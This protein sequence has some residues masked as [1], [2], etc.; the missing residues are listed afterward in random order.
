[1]KLNTYFFILNGLQASIILTTVA[2]T[3]SMPN[4]AKV[5][6]LSAVSIVCLALFAL[7]ATSRLRRGL[8][9][10]ETSVIEHNTDLST[11][12]GIDEFA[13]SA[14]QLSRQAEH[15]EAISEKNREQTQTLHEIHALISDSNSDSPP[16]SEQ[17]QKQLA[18]LANT[19]AKHLERFT[20]AASKVE[21]ISE[22]LHENTESQG[23]A[24]VKASTYLEQLSDVI[25]A[26]HGN[27]DGVI[28]KNT[29]AFQSVEHLITS[30]TQVKNELDNLEGAN[31]SSGRKL[32]DLGDPTRQA[33]GVVNVISDLATK[34]NML[35][36]NA[37]IESIRAGEQG[38]GFAVVATEVRKLAE[39]ASE[40][41]HEIN[42]LLELID[43]TVQDAVSS[44]N[45]DREQLQLQKR[46]LSTI[47]EMLGDYLAQSQSPQR[48]M[49]LI[50]DQTGNQLTLTNEILSAIELISEEARDNRQQLQDANW[51]A[52]SIAEIDEYLMM[53]V[54]RLT[55]CLQ[56][57]NFDSGT[58]VS[59]HQK[60]VLLVENQRH[61]HAGK[62]GS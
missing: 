7:I 1:M 51:T 21:L 35:A 17:I 10:L 8:H 3:D 31:R 12:V 9:M 29:D 59:N 14:K 52:K 27:A 25:Q 48:T 13:A 23:C 57:D 32:S 2:I 43:I 36:L 54:D 40:A 50:R 34:T 37:S 18:S 15:W 30:I 22:H 33:S 44:L 20:K 4:T 61:D 38:R 39:H 24:I 47:L 46:N 6:W 55:Q 28:K 42:V 41:A 49:E 26:I 58:S 45:L 56:P 16:S 5:I 62:V 19:L 11:S 53:T 60:P